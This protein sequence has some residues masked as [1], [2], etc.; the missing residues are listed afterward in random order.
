MICASVIGCYKGTLAPIFP[1]CF[2]VEIITPFHN[3]FTV[4]YHK[5]CLVHECVLPLFTFDNSFIDNLIM[6]YLLALRKVRDP[7]F[8]IPHLIHPQTKYL[9]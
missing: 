2:K 4:S 7:H 1:T 3:S 5:F 8:L 9:K 6:I